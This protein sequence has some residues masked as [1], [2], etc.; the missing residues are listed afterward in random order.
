MG[1]RS[2]AGYKCEVKIYS[3]DDDQSRH[4][5]LLIPP[6][7]GLRVVSGPLQEQHGNRERR[8]DLS[9]FLEVVLLIVKFS[10][11]DKILF[12]LSTITLHSISK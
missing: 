3:L 11:Q 8:T 5:G 6:L 4:H 12:L 1:L 2:G 7:R 10:I 9:L